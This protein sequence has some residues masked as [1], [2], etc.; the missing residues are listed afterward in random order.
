MREVTILVSKCG[1]K[2]QE[3]P[4]AKKPVGWG[5]CTHPSL[6]GKSYEL[7]DQN[8]DGITPSCPMYDKAIEVAE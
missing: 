2:K 6:R 4:Y 7:Y 3:C 5:S 8:R 1:S